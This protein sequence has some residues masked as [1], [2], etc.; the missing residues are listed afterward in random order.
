MADLS[1]GLREALGDVL[2]D[3]ERSKAHTASL[4]KMF[5]AF[6]LDGDLDEGLNMQDFFD[7]NVH[8]GSSNSSSSG[9]N[10]T[11]GKSDKNGQSESVKADAAADEAWYLA[12][13]VEKSLVRLLRSGGHGAGEGDEDVE[14]MKKTVRK[15]RREMDEQS[16]EISRLKSNRNS[17]N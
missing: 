5:Q 7:K 13:K 12:Q 17:M 1:R 10:N 16:R 14:Q 8:N 6:T 2:D 9:T 3:R 11:N 15:M 4:A